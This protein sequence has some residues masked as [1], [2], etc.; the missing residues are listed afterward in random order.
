MEDHAKKSLVLIVD[1]V[2]TNIDVLKG[3][4]H[5]NYDVKFALNG[6]TAIEIAS[7]EPHPDIILLDVMMPEMNGY[8][9]CAKLKQDSSTSHIPVIFVTA[10]DDLTGE[11]KGF[12]VGGVDYITKP[13]VPE[14][15]L[16]RVNTHL[17]LRE[18][19]KKL[20]QHALR[21]EKLADNKLDL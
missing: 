10:F 9:V 18:V 3:I 1:D 2:G 8:E 13:I 20:A 12:D 7:K 16:A 21:M 14:I 5:E 4:L 15:V 17:K 6:K 19:T 11:L